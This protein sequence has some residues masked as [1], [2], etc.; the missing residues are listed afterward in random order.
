MAHSPSTET[1]KHKRKKNSRIQYLFLAR[2]VPFFLFLHLLWVVACHRFH[3]LFHCAWLMNDDVCDPRCLSAHF[4]VCHLIFIAFPYLFVRND[5][6]SAS[7]NSSKMTIVGWSVW[8]CVTSNS[9]LPQ[10]RRFLLF[11]SYSLFASHARSFVRLSLSS[12]QR[13]FVDE[14]KIYL[15]STLFARFAHKNN[16]TARHLFMRHQN[17]VSTIFFFS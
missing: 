14:S 8:F 3:I 15:S 12:P 9:F 2:F 11:L 7:T 4:L 6:F 17:Y 1:A 13:P 16:F 10:F 5:N